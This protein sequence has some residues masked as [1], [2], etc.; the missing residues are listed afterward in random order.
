VRLT[1][2]IWRDGTTDPAEDAVV[3]LHFDPAAGQALSVRW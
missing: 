3:T 2:R 1:Q